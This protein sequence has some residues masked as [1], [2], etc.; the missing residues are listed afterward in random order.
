M[1][2]DEVVNINI[3][4][5]IGNTYVADYNGIWVEGYTKAAKGGRRP[6]M[7][8]QREESKTNIKLI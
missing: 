7:Q 4:F 8:Q 1:K 5:N 6:Q 2:Q 3:Q